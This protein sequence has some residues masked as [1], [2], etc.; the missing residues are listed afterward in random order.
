[1]IQK[2]PKIN[3]RRSTQSREERH[4]RLMASPSQTDAIEGPTTD[5]T[6]RRKTARV[7][8]LAIDPKPL[9]K[10]DSARTGATI[11]STIVPTTIDKIPGRPEK[12]RRAGGFLERS[13]RIVGI[14]MMANG[15]AKAIMSWA[16]SCVAPAE[17]K[18]S[19]KLKSDD[20]PRRMKRS[21]MSAG[22]T[23]AIRI[24][25][26]N[27]V[28]R[29]RGR[30]VI[31]NLPKPGEIENAEFTAQC[32]RRQD[33]AE[34]GHFPRGLTV[35]PSN[36]PIGYLLN[37]LQVMLCVENIHFGMAPWTTYRGSAA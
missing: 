29:R 19:L 4:R 28:N 33:F 16:N 34:D 14:P 9:R 37:E 2:P 31:K 7:E 15:T 23:A 13:R 30:A 20:S 6:M 5:G 18:R 10:K 11:I 27:S 32:P 21:T 26:S 36:R 8:G 25:P 1:M 12:H 17:A 35:L 24:I 3:A 22:V